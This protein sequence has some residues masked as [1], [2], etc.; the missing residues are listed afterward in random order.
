MKKNYV[1]ASY[2]LSIIYSR[3][4]NPFYNLNEA[5][6]M[7]KQATDEYDKLPPKKINEYNELNITN[8]NIF[9]HR[10]RISSALFKNAKMNHSV[11]SYNAFIEKNPWS[12]HVDSVIILRD[13]LA[14]SEAKA[15]GTAEA[16]QNFIQDY[17]KSSLLERATALYDKAIYQE[18]TLDNNFIDYVQFVNKFPLSPY[19]PDAEDAIYII[20]TKTGSL[21]SY[22]K[23]I[24]EYPENS[25]VS[26]AWRKMLNT[27]LQKEYSQNSIRAF[28][29]KF[30]DYPFKERL[31]EELR[32]ADLVILPFNDGNKWGFMDENGEA[33]I[34]AEFDG[35]VPFTEGLSIINKAGKYGYIN[36]AGEVI[37]DPIYT[38]A[39]RFHE[40]HAIV[41]YENKLGMINRSG[42][43]V[44]LPEYDDLG[45]LKGGFTYF[46]N[47]E[48]Y[49]YFDAKGMIRLKAQY[50]SASDFINKKAIVSYQGNYGVIDEFGT[51]LIPFKYEKIVPYDEGV[52]AV[53]IFNKW[54][55]LKTEGDT[56]TSI[57]YDYIGDKY[58]GISL[59]ELN[60]QFNYINAKGEEIRKEWIPTYSESRQLAI[61][62]N[63]YAKVQ[64]EDGFNLID[65][66]GLLL[67][68]SSKEDLGD[69]SDL[70]AFKNNDEW[71]YL[72]P[73]GSAVIKNKFSHAKSFQGHY[74]FAGG[75]PLWGM[76][77]K[78]GKYI[79]EAYFEDLSWLNDDLLLVK[80]R[81]SYGIMNSKGDTIVPF[82]YTSIEPFSV[83]LVQL[84]NK[85]GV[86]YFHLTDLKLIRKED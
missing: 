81:G 3:N 86:Y 58:G 51:T 5:L 26:G 31:E 2:G 59:V 66:N 80:T 75:A 68:K 43:F 49:G 60:D 36:K 56:L 24:E 19:R 17:P 50:S 15:I 11:I 55:L 72:S 65:T 63:N 62:K 37:I 25:N 84:V 82:K 10:D 29:E 64:Y 21:E 30:E 67:F 9:E 39:F 20:Y 85:S 34:P 23:F 33:I 77:D 8:K 47:S 52:F 32:L 61:F 69:Y 76:I 16:L 40:G 28:M 41:E 83:E 79:I 53:K 74:A 44:I 35:V 42:E 27:Y 14:F 7:I 70:I 12:E 13:N 54:G 78:R 22:H 45:D 6:I 73:Q 48:L 1:A 57:K 38:D 71:G 46:T 18:S 4:D